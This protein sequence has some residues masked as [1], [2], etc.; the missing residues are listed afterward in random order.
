MPKIDGAHVIIYSRNADADRGFLRD[1]L[2]LPNV[3][4]GDGWLIFAL[5]PAEV[6]IHPA[7]TDTVHELYLMTADLAGLV[8]AMAKR[9]VSCSP[10]R[11]LGWGVL[12]QVSLPGGGTLGVYEPRHAR[13]TW[14]EP[15]KR[16]VGGVVKKSRKA[17]KPRDATRRRTRR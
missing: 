9:G 16:E 3:D 11:N 6:A 2:G 10:P 5:P 14:S 13:P 12:T 7:D 1:V 17:S 4:V 15:A 8:D